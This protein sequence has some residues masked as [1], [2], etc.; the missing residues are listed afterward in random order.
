[1]ETQTNIPVIKFLHVPKQNESLA[2][3]G[4]ADNSSDPVYGGYSVGYRIV[5]SGAQLEM[6]FA[7][8]INA[9]AEIR[10][11]FSKAEARSLIRDRFEGGQTL[12]LNSLQLAPRCF[13]APVSFSGLTSH[14]IETLVSTFSRENQQRLRHHVTTGFKGFVPNLGRGFKKAR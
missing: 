4:I 9:D 13:M 3:F 14:L 8:C 5:D 11:V 7:F 2:M 1:M 6:S 10:D 12:K